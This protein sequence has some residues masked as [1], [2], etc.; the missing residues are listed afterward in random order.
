MR[1]RELQIEE[2][3]NLRSLRVTFNDS[4][5]Y[6]VLVGENGAGKSNLTEAIALIFR[7]LDLGEVC[8]FSYNI[9]Y[10]VGG[11]RVRVDAAKGQWPDIRATDPSDTE[12][13]LFSLADESYKPVTRR[14]FLES[15]VEGRPRYRP[16]F[17]FGYY[18][19]PSDRL[20]AVFEKHQERFYSAIIKPLSSDKSE[21]RPDPNELRRLF[22]AQTLHGQF[23]L[24]AFF[25]SQGED[26]D[27]DRTFI[28]ERLQIDGLDSVLFVLHQPRWAKR[29]GGDRRF[30]GAE[31]EVQEFLGR[32][33]EAAL[34]PMRA[35][36]RYST[37]LTKAQNVE[38]LYLFLQDARALASV[39][40]SY[41]DQ[42]RFFTALESTHLS[43]VL[44][45]VRT[46]VRMTEAAGGGAVDYRDLSEGEQQ[47]L[48]V[49]G[50]LK[51]TARDEALFLL[52]EPDTHL[53]PVWSVEYL[54]FLNH[55]MALRQRANSCHIVMNTH[56]PLVFS[57]LDRTE[58]V[59]MTR[60]ADGTAQVSVPDHSPKGM[61]VGAILT[62]DLFRLRSTLDP[63]T[64]EDLDS[65]RLLAMKERSPSE[66]ADFRRLSGRLRKLGLTM[67]SRD[68][69]YELFLRAWT[70]HEDPAWLAEPELTPEEH[71]A[72]E[73]LADTI[74]AE[75]REELD[76]G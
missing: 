44:F 2:F 54:D 9:E 71:E 69:L 3:K 70:E 73:Q 68:P 72:R 21:V 34:L 52:D 33:Y 66:E 31:G 8:G 49:L 48:L 55:F 67:A 25:M 1:L 37:G 4:S 19:G 62:S 23:A 50:L 65:H 76:R 40:K 18:S 5:P 57:R 32:L 24:L 39:Y 13:Q 64:Q 14:A 26:G 17:V 6:T 41:S 45:E 43:R 38:H 53:N 20:R 28:R 10:E 11:I 63:D 22:Y 42:Y 12:D 47:L 75:L 51:F 59:I 30:W 27:E 56:D 36:R 74:V 61:G 7:N 58:V 16:T 15:M 35:G 60:G 46:R 29:S